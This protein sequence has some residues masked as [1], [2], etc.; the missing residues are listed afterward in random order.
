MK[1][2]RDISA[3]HLVRA[4]GRIGYSVI[5]QSGSHLTLQHE[6]RSDWHVGLPN[7]NPL[8]VGML[9]AVLKTVAAQQSVSLDE[10]IRRL[11]LR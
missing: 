11:K 4:L 8:K 2:P 10:L 3:E 9:H 7:H 1:L 6:Q 5:R